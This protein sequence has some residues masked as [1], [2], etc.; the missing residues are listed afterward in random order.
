MGSY[1]T[2]GVSR[3]VVSR[4][5]VVSRGVPWPPRDP[6][7]GHPQVVHV[8]I[9]PPSTIPTGLPGL[10]LFYPSHGKQQTPS[11]SVRVSQHSVRIL[12]RRGFSA[13][14]TLMIIGK[15]WVVQ[16]GER[17]TFRRRGREMGIP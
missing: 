1:C 4:S 8:V 11:L 5:V 16:V 2:R 6:L 9:N 7:Y 13:Q 17:G 14:G 3:S 15:G 12:R 10:L